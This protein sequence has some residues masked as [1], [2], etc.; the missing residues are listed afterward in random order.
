[1][2]LYSDLRRPGGIYHTTG[3]TKYY[4]EFAGFLMKLKNTRA[5]DRL[6]RVWDAKKPVPHLYWRTPPGIEEPVEDSWGKTFDDTPVTLEGMVAAASRT[7]K[8]NK[9]TMQPQRWNA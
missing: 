3:P 1:M 5:Y 7:Y 4:V 2:F 9:S 8:K 6:K